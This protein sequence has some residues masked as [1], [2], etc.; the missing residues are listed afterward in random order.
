MDANVVAD[1]IQ[2]GICQLVL[3]NVDVVKLN[4]LVVGTHQVND[5]GVLRVVHLVILFLLFPN[6]VPFFVFIVCLFEVFIDFIYF[7]RCEIQ[8][9]LIVLLNFNQIF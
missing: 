4:E 3:L 9:H 1:L 8:R 6:L 2:N 5:A 7:I